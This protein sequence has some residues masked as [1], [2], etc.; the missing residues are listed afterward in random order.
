MR[1]EQATPA[2]SVG[3]M[4]KLKHFASSRLCPMQ[5]NN[6]PIT[7]IKIMRKRAVLAYIATVACQI[8]PLPMLTAGEKRLS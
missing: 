6:F 7:V 2:I 4:E 5:R 8:V 3:G 1:A